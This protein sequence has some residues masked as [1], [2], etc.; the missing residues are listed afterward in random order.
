[1]L[2]IRLRFH[3]IFKAQRYFPN[4]ADFELFPPVESKMFVSIFDLDSSTS[5]N[6]DQLQEKRT[7]TG[8][9]SR[10]VVKCMFKI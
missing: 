3:L 9:M 5:S 6:D 2:S 4:T 10:H 8:H 7:V 1:M